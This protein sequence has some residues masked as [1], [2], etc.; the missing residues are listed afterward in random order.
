MILKQ[1]KTKTLVGMHP[2]V[3]N[4]L[5]LGTDTTVRNTMNLPLCLFA[6]SLKVISCGIATAVI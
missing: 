4:A 5:N 1:V 6:L 3:E 2:S